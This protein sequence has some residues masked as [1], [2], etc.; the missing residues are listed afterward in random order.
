MKGSKYMR[1]QSYLY[2]S[3]LL[4]E[5]QILELIKKKES[6]SQSKIA[7]ET[8]LTVAMVNNYIARLTNKEYIKK[9]SISG[10]LMKY[11]ITEKGE[12]RIRYHLFSWTAE[13]LDIYSIVKTKLLLFIQENILSNHSKVILYGAGEV[14]EVLFNAI[15]ESEKIKIIGIVDDDINKVGSL[16]YNLKIQEFSKIDEMRP[17]IIIVTSWNYGDLITNKL[18][19]SFKNDYEIINISSIGKKDND[20]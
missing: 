2:P 4:R 19:K 7:K 3:P 11:I 15:Q 9:H 20:T 6:I 10:N 16:F 17:D 12:K 1:Y 8:G 13:L 14:A 5:L 18:Y